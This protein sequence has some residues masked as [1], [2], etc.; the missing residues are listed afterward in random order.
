M[1][2]PKESGE[3][4]KMA[5]LVKL[6]AERT[7]AATGGVGE[8]IWYDAV[9]ADG[10][11]KWQDELNEKNAD[12]FLHCD[13]IFLN[14]NW[15]AENLKK[16]LDTLRSRNAI[17]RSTDI[18]VGIDVF[19]RGCL[20]GFDCNKSLEMIRG[21]SSS[22]SSSSSSTDTALSVAVFAAGW[23][24]E[25]IQEDIHGAPL[26]QES[27]L[28]GKLARLLVGKTVFNRAA[29]LLL[30]YFPHLHELNFL[31]TGRTIIPDRTSRPAEADKI[32]EAFLSRECRFW[33]LLEPFMY[34]RGPAAVEDPDEA[35]ERRVLFST[36]F[37]SGCSEKG[38]GWRLD[39]AAQQP[40]P[41]FMEEHTLRTPPR[42]GSGLM[43]KRDDDE[44]TETESPSTTPLLVCR[45]VRRRG[46]ALAIEVEAA[47][48]V[49]GDADYKLAILGDGNK[50]REIERA[51]TE[52]RADIFAVPEDLHVVEAMGVI[53]GR[54][55]LTINSVRVLHFKHLPNL[56]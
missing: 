46:F 3:V 11:L 55:R 48:A 6:L 7:K 37:S 47:G 15:K 16:S 41:S 30:W 13:G 40:Q 33:S 27:G 26:G 35:A 8:V 28:V 4:G 1:P 43:L 23:T 42:C 21:A 52:E 10:E 17:G 22:S 36:D 5:E 49:G 2:S 34:L 14:Y 39:L 50:L 32:G 31:K 38:G 19:G 45:F 44:A 29:R 18:Y 24:H 53:L 51:A 56:I 12:F 20:G 9:T 25:K 54:P